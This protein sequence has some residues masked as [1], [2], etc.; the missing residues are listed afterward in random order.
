MET[1]IDK[2]NK[3]VNHGNKS[4]LPYKIKDIEH[5]IKWFDTE[6]VQ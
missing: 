3:W 2:T 6:L 4:N 1:E 5:F